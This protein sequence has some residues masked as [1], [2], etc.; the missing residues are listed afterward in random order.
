MPGFSFFGGQINLPAQE[1]SLD[2]FGFEGIGRFL[3]C[4]HA[5][6]GASRGCSKGD[7]VDFLVVKK[8]RAFTIVFLRPVQAFD[9]TEAAWNVG[10]RE[11]FERTAQGLL[12]FGRSSEE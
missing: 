2:A 11:R 1:R 8:Q 5:R 10:W 6:A 12:V 4:F 9:S 7:R 3:E